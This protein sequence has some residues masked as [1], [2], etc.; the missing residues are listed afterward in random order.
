MTDAT[1][2]P[3]LGEHIAPPVKY[4]A[5]KRY[6]SNIGAIVGLIFVVIE[7]FACTFP[8]LI[9]KYPQNDQN[10]LN[11]R[12]PP[13]TTHWFGTDNLGRDQFSEVLHAGLVSIR[14]GFMVAILAT[15]IGATVGAVA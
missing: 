13:S 14:I 12:L 11:A 10:L 15:L 5:I 1:V 3:E 4:R 2:L 9:T 6:C 8:S 7:T